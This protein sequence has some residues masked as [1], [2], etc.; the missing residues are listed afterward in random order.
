MGLRKA[1]KT[2]EHDEISDIVI[3]GR[4]RVRPSTPTQASWGG[5]QT[6]SSC[7]RPEQGPRAILRQVVPLQHGGQVS[8]GS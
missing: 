2:L 1:A 4:W 8:S 3:H 5:D 7:Q 6:H